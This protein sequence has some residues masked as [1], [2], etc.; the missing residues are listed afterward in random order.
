MQTQSGESTFSMSN[1]ATH[2]LID[3][4]DLKNELSSCQVSCGANRSLAKIL[5]KSK[6]TSQVLLGV[7]VTPL[8]K[9]SQKSDLV[10]QVHFTWS[11]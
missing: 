2:Q 6:A 10:L 9:G 7:T 4:N 8:D 3:C 5:Q 1:A 11:S